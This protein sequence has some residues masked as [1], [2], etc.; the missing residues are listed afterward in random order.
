M[1]IIYLPLFI[2]KLFFI[3]LE[4]YLFLFIYYLIYLY[5]YFNLFINILLF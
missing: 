5:F 4:N 2:L 1:K 3:I